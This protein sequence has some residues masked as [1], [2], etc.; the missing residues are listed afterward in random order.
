VSHTSSSLLIGRCRRLADPPPRRRSSRSRHRLL[1]LPLPKFPSTREKKARIHPRRPQNAMVLK[2]VLR[3]MSRVTTGLVWVKAGSVS[4]QIQRENPSLQREP[5]R[6]SPVFRICVDNLVL[7][8]SNGLMLSLYA[9]V[10]LT[11]C[12][13]LNSQIQLFSPVTRYS[14]WLSLL[15]AQQPEAPSR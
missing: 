6:E 11:P 1:S 14:N 5:P 15:R 7:V 10:I 2:M 9:S 4:S 12:V 8:S 3:P 13:N